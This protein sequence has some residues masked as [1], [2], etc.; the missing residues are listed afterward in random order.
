MG[1]IKIELLAKST[2]LW[3]IWTVLVP[4]HDWCFF[5][6]LSDV[7]S[8]VHLSTLQCQYLSFIRDTHLTASDKSYRALAGIEPFTQ[9]FYITVSGDLNHYATDAAA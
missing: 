4:G 7:L 1:Q 5:V 6:A 2:S 8:D 9:R 3:F